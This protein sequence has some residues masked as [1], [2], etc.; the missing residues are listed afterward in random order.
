[1]GHSPTKILITGSSSGLGRF[2]HESFPGSRGLRRQDHLEDITPKKGFDAII[3]CAFRRCQDVQN[4][5]LA[6]IVEDNCFLTRKLLAIP[7]KKFIYLSSNTVYPSTGKSLRKE[8]QNILVEKVETL[9]GVLKL[10]NEEIIKARSPNYCILRATSLLGHSMKSNTLTRI[11]FEDFPKVS[12][13]ADSKLHCVL[14]E[15]ARA[16]IAH[17]L[18][19]DLKGVFNLASSDSIKLSDVAKHFNKKVTYGDYHYEPGKI[20]ISKLVFHLPELKKTSWQNIELFYKS[21]MKKT[22]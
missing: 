15:D 6:Q 12:L 11:L 21:E 18:K 3:H 22:A 1:M 13:T 20:D 4:S 9:A 7:H 19:K 17:A 5:E 10:M 8:E 2:L 14:Y 16:V